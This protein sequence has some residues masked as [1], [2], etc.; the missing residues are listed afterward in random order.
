MQRRDAIARRTF[1]KGAAAFTA[2]VATPAEQSFAQH[3]VPNSSGSEAP[4]LKAPAN[5]C[6]CH[7]HIYDAVR[8]PPVRPGSR[9][10]A[11]ASIAEY[12]LL[13]KRNGTARAVIVT[14]AVYVT[15]NRVTPDAIQKLG[16]APRLPLIHPS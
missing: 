10:Q 7:M 6:D 16:N 5:A 14:P 15:A 13:Q 4:N 8:F 3:A 2:A 9:P 1:L 11:N 12:R